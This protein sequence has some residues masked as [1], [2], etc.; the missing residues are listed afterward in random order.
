MRQKSLK[1]QADAILKMAK[2]AGLDDN[3]FFSTTFKRYQ[4]QLHILDELEKMI[5]EKGVVVNKSYVKG[6]KNLYSN[7]AVVDFNR[8]TDSANKTVATLLRI[9][10]IFDA[11][12]TGEESDPLIDMINGGE[13]DDR[14]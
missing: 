13:E 4:V 6:E 2:D 5:E 14:K 10:K 8:T 7:P 9:L 11:D 3:F 12:L 1:A